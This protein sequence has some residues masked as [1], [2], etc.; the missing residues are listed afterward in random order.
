MTMR[1][2][3]KGSARPPK[4]GRLGDEAQLLASVPDTDDAEAT[5]GPDV[6]GDDADTPHSPMRAIRA[7]CLNCVC[8]SAKEV[9]RCHLTRC[10]LWPFRLGRNPFRQKR[11]LTDEQKAA[12]AERLKQAREARKAAAG[13]ET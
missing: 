4:S 8:G 6:G 13:E 3:T 1:L 11:V 5:T 9:Q 12:G 7:K 10:A 2:P